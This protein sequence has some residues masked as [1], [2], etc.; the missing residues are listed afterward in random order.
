MNKIVIIM[1][2]KQKAVSNIDNFRTF[3]VDLW[4]ILY[5]ITGDVEM[6][7]MTGKSTIDN[8]LIDRFIIKIRHWHS[9]I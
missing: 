9:S 8:Y 1:N 5:P 4:N 3:R 2:K 7:R 6:Y